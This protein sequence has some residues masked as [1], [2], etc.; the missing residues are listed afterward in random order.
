[1][2]TLFEQ[3][4]QGKIWPL[5]G[6]VHPPTNKAIASAKPIAQLPIPE[7]LIIPIKQHIG[8]AGRLIVK[9]GDNVLKGQALTE[10]TQNM[11]LPVHA[12]T[13]GQV[14]R[15]ADHPIA[16][17]SGLKEPCIFIKTDGQDNWIAREP[18]PHYTGETPEYLVNKIKMA[19]ISGLG[20]AGFPAYVKSASLRKI[21]YLIVNATECEPYICADDA[22]IRQDAESIIQGIDII[23]NLVNPEKILIGIEDDKPEAIKRL[24]DVTE[25]RH[26]IDVRVFP[27]RY[28]SGGEKQLIHILTGQQVPS[29]GL[30]IDVGILVHNTGTLHAIYK[31]VMC[32]EPCIS[33]I[34][35]VTGGAVANQQN[36][37]VLIGTPVKELLNFCEFTPSKNQRVIM[38]GPMMGFTLGTTDIPIAKISNCILAPK[39]G[40]LPAPENEMDCIRCSACADACPVSLLPQQ[41]F[42]YSKAKDYP[43]AESYNL[44]DCIE[45]GA[46]AYV[47]PSEIPLVHYYRQAKAEIKAIAAEKQQA[48]QAKKRF[49]ARK[50]RLER[51]AEERAQKQKEAAEKRKQ[52]MAKAAALAP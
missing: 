47:C 3:V 33:R 45:C 25:H 49:E 36:V 13:S 18:N 28:P 52:A 21:N 19:G 22:L 29:G 41:L 20:G 5:I 14:V 37:E 48:E 31:A 51:D 43:T 26:D 34:V 42:W 4:N 8:V 27:S 16:H 24:Q 40:E 50:L 1:M 11:S 10:P 38:G 46:C 12:S 39:Q 30:P 23:A 35:T 9:E 32:D 44:K 2:E 6:G 7:M 17:A 15:I